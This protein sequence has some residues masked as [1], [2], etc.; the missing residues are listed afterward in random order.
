[1]SNRKLHIDALRLF[2]IALVVCNHTVLYKY[3]V[4]AYTDNQFIKCIGYVW[5]EIC[6]M[7]V[8][9]FFMISG[10]LLINREESIRFVL[11]HRVLPFLIFFGLFCIIQILHGSISFGDPLTVKSFVMH[12]YAGSKYADANWFMFAYAGLLLMLPFTRNMIRGLDKKH[13]LYIINLQIIICGLMPSFLFFV[14]SFN[15]PIM[16]SLHSY[17]PFAF[18]ATSLPFSGMQYL[19]FMLIGYFAEYMIDTQSFS[20]K[21]WCLT[22]MLAIACL[23]FGA[24]MMLYHNSRTDNFTE[25]T[26]FLTSFLTIPLITLYIG[27]KHL[28]RKACHV[29]IFSKLVISMGSATI[30]VFALENILRHYF[31]FLCHD[32][33][34]YIASDMSLMHVI[35][36]NV[37]LIIFVVISGC[38]IGHICKKIPGLKW[39]LGNKGQQRHCGKK[40][41]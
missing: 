10:A 28:L 33:A 29:S 17:F 11:T 41:S 13:Y 3:G 38:F 30:M 18:N 8:P 32:I 5:A 22:S 26:P 23:I 19:Y 24:V 40:V 6:K 7:G 2:A 20:R 21:H 9:L 39:I 31:S 35:I 16:P 37:I 15:T 36:E 1:M 12:L 34:S 25:T 14:S 27:S 4:S